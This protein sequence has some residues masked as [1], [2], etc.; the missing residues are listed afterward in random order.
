MTEDGPHTELP[1]SPNRS[2]LPQ[3]DADDE[4]DVDLADV[5]L[6]EEDQLRA[7]TIPEGVEF[8]G[9]GFASLD[10]YFRRELEDLVDPAAAWILECLD[11]QEIQA[12]FEGNRFRYFIER[13]HVFR[14]EVP[15]PD[16]RGPFWMGRGC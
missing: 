2:P 15:P 12:R 4:V 8:L 11:Y 10:H 3:V 9:D 13:G 14:C 6:G 7:D 5:D 1:M 16:P